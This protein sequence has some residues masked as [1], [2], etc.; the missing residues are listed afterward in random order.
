MSLGDA[1]FIRREDV[2]DWFNKNWKRD[3]VISALLK[4][5]LAPRSVLEI[6]C[7]NGWRLGRIRE[8][9][10]CRCC[11]IDPSEIAISKATRPDI[12]LRVGTASYLGKDTHDIVIFGF[13]LYLCRKEGLFKIAS[14]A[15]RVLENGG[16][17][18]LYDFHPETAYSNVC[19]DESWSNYKMQYVN[20]FSWHPHYRIVYRNV[21]RNPEDITENLSVYILKKKSF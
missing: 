10:G 15:D 1:Y 5:E 13:C 4:L 17:L 14:E 6:G 11:G 2:L 21:F 8:A 19:P 18:V 7:S 12:E 9:F 16:Y 20:M 3:P